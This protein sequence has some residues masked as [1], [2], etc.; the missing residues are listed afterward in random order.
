MPVDMQAA[1]FI[2]DLHATLSTPDVA[3]TRLDG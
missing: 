3:G 1:P 2:I